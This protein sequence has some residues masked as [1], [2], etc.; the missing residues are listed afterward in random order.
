MR[1]GKSPRP[2]LYLL[3]AV[4]F[5]FS[6]S[7]THTEGLQGTTV[8]AL[9]PFWNQL[10]N[11]KQVIAPPGF[12]EENQRLELENQQL[13][14]EIRRFQKIL[15][16]EIFIEKLAEQNGEKPPHLGKIREHERKKLLVLELQS[17][18][19]QVIFRSPSSW[20][21]TLWVH[22]GQVD[23][24]KL[25]RDVVAKNS[26]VVIGNA[27][28]G[29]VE[30]VGKKQSR[31][32][33]IT[34]ALLTPSVRAVRNIEGKIWHLGK[35]ELKGSLKTEWRTN[36]RLLKGTGFNYNFAD[37]EGPERDLRTG[38]PLGNNTHLPPLPIVL[39]EDLLITTGMDG[40]FPAGL[41][42][43]QVTKVHNLQEGDFC[44]E[45]EALPCCGGLDDLT[46]V[47]ILPPLGYDPTDQPP[48]LGRSF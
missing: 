47:V 35:G 14:N 3:A 18:P 7:K 1:K 24:E 42:V 40:V 37:A 21:S 16:H 10:N 39:A 25:G 5:L 23:N 6:L 46:T 32:R 36:S 12:Q 30:Y 33:L 31:V 44:Y 8:A 27:V 22:A 38:E 43:A 4:L 17:Y 41:F 26:P 11:I 45:L 2:Y 29:V 20:D 34:D 19:A 15:G 28:V 48:P 13:K 9:A